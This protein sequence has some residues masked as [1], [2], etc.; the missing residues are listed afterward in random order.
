M[1]NLSISGKLCVAE[2]WIADQ[3]LSGIAVSSQRIA[4]GLDLRLDGV[5]Y[6]RSALEMSSETTIRNSVGIARKPVMGLAGQHDSRL[7][8]LQRAFSTAQ[9]CRSKG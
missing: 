7:Q 9:L 3:A 1:R 5:R 8:A 6:R 4:D 2:D